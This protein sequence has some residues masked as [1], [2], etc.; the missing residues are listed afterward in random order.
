MDAR[1][2]LKPYPS[3]LTNQEV[4][5]QP[6]HQTLLRVSNIPPPQTTGRYHL[7]LSFPGAVLAPSPLEWAR[8]QGVPLL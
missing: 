3:D 6:F 2:A 7:S 8:G 1:A 4:V 5:L